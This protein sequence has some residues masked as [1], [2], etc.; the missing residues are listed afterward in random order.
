MNW[1]LLHR[2]YKICRVLFQR[3]LKRWP[4]RFPL[5][6]IDARSAGDSAGLV[7]HIVVEI[8]AAVCF[9]QGH[10]FRGFPGRT[11]VIFQVVGRTTEGC[12]GAAGTDIVCSTAG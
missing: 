10:F 4:M 5:S 12:R 11:W 8:L 6:N 3:I 2:N 1:V 7:S 9:F